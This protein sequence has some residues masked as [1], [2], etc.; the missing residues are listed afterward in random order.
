M[1]PVALHVAT[2]A[3][4]PVSRILSA[5]GATVIVVQP[6]ISVADMAAT[7]PTRYRGIKTLLEP[8]RI[9][10]FLKTLSDKVFARK[11]SRE[12]S[13]VRCLKRPCNRWLI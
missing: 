5:P 8:K 7:K 1:L 11:T 10:D 4:L 6:T 3:A 9:K 12:S 13:S 2:S